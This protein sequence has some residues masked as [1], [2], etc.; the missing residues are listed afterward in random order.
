MTDD[1]GEQL[2]RATVKELQGIFR[3]WA[4]FQFRVFRNR[5]RCDHRNRMMLY[6]HSDYCPD[7]GRVVPRDDG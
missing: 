5:A 3:D 2:P 1:M 4:R 7:C 6:A